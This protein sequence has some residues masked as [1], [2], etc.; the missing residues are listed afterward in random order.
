MA[1]LCSGQRPLLAGLRRSYANIDRKPMAKER[2][3]TKRLP[4]ILTAPKRTMLGG[5]S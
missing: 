1:N 5:R 3:V 2:T 4:S